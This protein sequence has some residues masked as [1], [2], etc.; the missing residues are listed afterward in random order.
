MLQWTEAIGELDGPHHASAVFAKVPVIVRL[1]LLDEVEVPVP[2]GLQ[3]LQQT[4]TPTCQRAQGHG[5]GLFAQQSYRGLE[6]HVVLRDGN[7]AH[8]GSEPCQPASRE[9]R[10][11]R[12][13][14]E[15][16]KKGTGGVNNARAREEDAL[17][18]VCIG[19]GDHH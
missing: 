8:T 1:D 6:Q 18:L 13:D 7:A 11:T 17:R 19:M 5:W 4:D 16:A 9:Q 10:K 15:E 14:S 2:L 12:R 3:D